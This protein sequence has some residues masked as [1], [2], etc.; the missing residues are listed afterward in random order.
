MGQRGS[1]LVGYEA[2][3]QVGKWASGLMFLWVNGLC[4][5][6]RL[7]GLKLDL[8]LVPTIQSGA[9]LPQVFFSPGFLPNF[10]GDIFGR[11]DDVFVFRQL[12]SRLLYV[13][14]LEI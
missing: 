12:S 7:S 9:I 10:F 13:G 1:G 2:G 5:L 6:W 14:E 3:M 11:M 4:G 8:S